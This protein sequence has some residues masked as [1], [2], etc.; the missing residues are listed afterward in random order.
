MELFRIIL[1]ILLCLKRVR[2]WVMFGI[3]RNVPDHVGRV[4]IKGILKKCINQIQAASPSQEMPGSPPPAPI[5]PAVPIPK[6]LLAN[7]VRD[8]AQ[9]MKF[10]R[11]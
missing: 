9:I 1:R 2:M 3:G 6:P 10:T 8:R 5:P 7:Q 4:K 11:E